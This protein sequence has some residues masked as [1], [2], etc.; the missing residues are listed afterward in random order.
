ARAREPRRNLIAN[1]AIGAGADD[2]HA[3]AFRADNELTELD[4]AFGQPLLGATIGCARREHDKRLLEL[5]SDFTQHRVRTFG[6]NRD[7][8]VLLAGVDSHAG[9]ERLIVV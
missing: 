6:T 1:A 9:D 8:G 7:L 2:Q 4:E 3:P 5:E